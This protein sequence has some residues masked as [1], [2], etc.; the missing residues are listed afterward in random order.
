MDMR[1]APT[2]I[3]M[4]G[5]GGSGPRHWQS[6]WVQRVP[7]ARRVVQADWTSPMRSVWVDALARQILQAPSPV[8][9]VAHSLGCIAAVHLPGAEVGDLDEI[10]A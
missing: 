1:S 9:V 5:W 2:T 10:F 7:G 4:P 8:L 3:I 6:L